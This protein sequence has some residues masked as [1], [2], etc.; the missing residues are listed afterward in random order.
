VLLLLEQR[1][2]D[3]EISDQLCI[4]LE[5]VKTHTKHVREK[6]NANSRRNAVSKAVA[7]NTL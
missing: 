7:L 4:S 3:K 6:L 1:Q 2:S 5:T